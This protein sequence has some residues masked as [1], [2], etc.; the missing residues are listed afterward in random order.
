MLLPGFCGAKLLGVVNSLLMATIHSSL[1]PRPGFVGTLFQFFGICVNCYKTFSYNAFEN[2]LNYALPS[3]HLRAQSVMNS[4]KYYHCLQFM[5]IYTI[6]NLIN[7]FMCILLKCHDL[8][9]SC[10]IIDFFTSLH[11]KTILH[12]V[13]SML[14]IY[15]FEL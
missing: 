2:F 9:K 8:L 7:H 14:I 6:F 11:F 1:I 13:I 5:F 15:N 12:C 10:L 4:F 3:S